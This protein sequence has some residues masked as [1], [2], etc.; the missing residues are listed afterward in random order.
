MSNINKIKISGTEY[1]IVDSAATSAVSTEQAR[2]ALAESAIR[3][4]LETLSK[5][6]VTDVKIGDTSVV[7]DNVATLKN[8]TVVAEGTSDSQHLIRVTGTQL[9][10]PSD[11][12]EVVLQADNFKTTTSSTNSYF[13]I[14]QD[15][16]ALV[17][18]SASLPEVLF[19][20]AEETITSDNS[21]VNGKTNT[22]GA[23]IVVNCNEGNVYSDTPMIALTPSIMGATND[24]GYLVTIGL[25]GFKLK[26]VITD[27]TAGT[28]KIG[29]NYTQNDLITANSGVKTIGTDIAPLVDGK[30]PSSYMPETTVSAED[31]TDDTN[32]YADLF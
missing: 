28:Y 18:S 11:S 15:Q 6:A 19:T 31:Y 13:E 26:K 3:S 27:A 12:Q 1:N 24:T 16:V 23:I 9:T 8:T 29:D 25:D 7:S 20:K 5:S 17:N 4:D 14:R 10:T 22:T 32:D 2:A 21:S 30:L